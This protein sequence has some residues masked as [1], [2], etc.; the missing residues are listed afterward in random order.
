MLRNVLCSNSVPFVDLV[1]SVVIASA[2]AL[3]AS[4]VARVLLSSSL[5]MDSFHSCGTSYTSRVK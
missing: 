1:G 2:Y 5:M 3:V 4:V